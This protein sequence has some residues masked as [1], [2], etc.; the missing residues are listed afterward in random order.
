MQ[1][2]AVARATTPAAGG[3]RGRRRRRRREGGGGIAPQQRV[4]FPKL[5]QKPQKLSA[6]IHAE[7]RF[8]HT[9]AP[10]P[11]LGTLW[12]GCV[13]DFSVFTVLRRHSGCAT[14]TK[15]KVV[16]WALTNKGWAAIA[17]SIESCLPPPP[18]PAT[19]SHTRLILART[20]RLLLLLI[21]SVVYMERC[22][23][24]PTTLSEP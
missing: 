5:D 20:R 1:P 18:P 21:A 8:R 13:Q 23:P 24:F 2:K 15:L 11:R 14:K 9:A 19:D 16:L 3:G 4:T 17:S 7:K 6:Q 10:P 22:Q 12:G